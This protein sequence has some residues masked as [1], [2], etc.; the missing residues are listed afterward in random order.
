M[1]ALM[2]CVHDRVSGDVGVCWCSSRRGVKLERAKVGEGG[3][4][5]IWFPNHTAGE[6]KM[7]FVQNLSQQAREGNRN[8]FD[9]VGRQVVQSVGSSRRR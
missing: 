7:I 9:G 2:C 3:A 4:V 8:V 6:E 5:T 1:C